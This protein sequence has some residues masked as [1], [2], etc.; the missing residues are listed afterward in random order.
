MLEE[1][2]L[3]ETLVRLRKAGKLDV[4]TTRRDR[5]EVGEAVVAAEI[6]ARIIKTKRKCPSIRCSSIL[7]CFNA[8]INWRPLSITSR[9]CIGCAKPRCSFEKSVNF[10]PN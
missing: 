1:K 9:M 2:L 8:M 3:W 7:L 6:A 4:P 10:A 5:T